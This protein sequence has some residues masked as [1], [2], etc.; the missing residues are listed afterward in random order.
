MQI[1]PTGSDP[2]YME[3]DLT[4]MLASGAGILVQTG[5]RFLVAGP[6]SNRF[7]F[8]GEDLVYGPSGWPIAGTIHS[9]EYRLG[10]SVLYSQ[11]SPPFTLDA[12]MLHGLAE[13]PG[14]VTH[15]L[16]PGNDTLHGSDLDDLITDLAGHNVFYGND[17]RDTITAG[18]GNDH[19]YGASPDGGPDGAD[20]IDGGNGGDYIQGNAGNDQLLGRGG[21]DRING[22]ADNDIIIGG[23]DNDTLNGNRGADAVSGDEGNDVLRGGQGD[24][25]LLGGTGNDV[26][27]GDR[28]VDVL[29]GGA[30][31]DIFI[32][33]TDTS[34]IGSRIDSIKDFVG[35][36]DHI[37][38]GFIPATM[39]SDNTSGPAPSDHTIAKA[40]A[41]AQAQMDAHPG[42][43]EVVVV[44]GSEFLRMFWA[45]DGGN[46]VDSVVE[47]GGTFP[48]G[49]GPSDFIAA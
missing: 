13:K 34:P 40:F 43:H 24:D 30:G 1:F 29:Y 5:T 26:L 9:F 37:A 32:F 35:G 19:L 14:D 45:S 16:L 23:A 18:D 22:G 3:L 27:M 49:F 20:I 36:V 41:K 44:G 42:D 8:G 39:L 47:L 2:L 33:G 28:G 31:R 7:D 4:R 25:T 6:D 46:I 38:I 15:L 48:T 10:N 17:G 21:S 11:S 12:A